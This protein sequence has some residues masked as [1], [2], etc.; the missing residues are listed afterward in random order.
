MQRSL[1]TQNFSAEEGA[2]I[3]NN[4]TLTLEESE[5]IENRGWEHFAGIT[6]SALVTQGSLICGNLI[7]DFDNNNQLIPSN[8]YLPALTVD[9]SSTVCDE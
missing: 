6:G 1:V 9:A 2:G 8:A 5:V 3:L 7:E 4:G